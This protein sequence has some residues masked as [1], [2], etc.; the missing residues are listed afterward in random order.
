MGVCAGALSGENTLY[1]VMIKCI[2]GLGNPDENRYG[3]KRV[4]S[5]FYVKYDG[6]VYDIKTESGRINLN[7]VNSS[8]S[9]HSG[10][11]VGSGGSVGLTRLKDL[12]HNTDV[13]RGNAVLAA[14]SGTVSAITPAP[15]GGVFVQVNKEKHFIPR[16]L[17]NAVT[18]GQHVNKGDKLSTYG[19]VRPR[20]VLE[21]TGDIRKTQ[22]VLIEELKGAYGGAKFKRKILETAVKPMTDRAQITDAGDGDREYGVH[23][24]EVYVRAKLE[25]Y[26]DKL[27][28]RGLKPIVFTPILL[29]ITQIPHH[30]EDVIASL[31]HERI[32]ENLQKAPALNKEINFGPKGHILARLGLKHF[33]SIDRLKRGG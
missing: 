14:E 27:K 30:S 28:L 1:H 8:N 23:P 3:A 5:L 7:G 16:E 4:E 22:D 25:D 11:A 18:V 17:G 2:P 31:A 24:G 10:S 21:T 26:N 12:L 15:T 20:D 13:A 29:G 19:N 32:K 9:F 33:D 6:L